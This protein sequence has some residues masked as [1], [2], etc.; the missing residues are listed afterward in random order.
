M[1]V[2]WNRIYHHSPWVIFLCS[3]VALPF[4]TI[5]GYL[6]PNFWWS[7]PILAKCFMVNSQFFM[8]NVRLGL[9]LIMLFNF[10]PSISQSFWIF[11]V[12]HIEAI[13]SV[14]LPKDFPPVAA[15]TFKK[16]RLGDLEATQ[17][18]DAGGH[19]GAWQSFLMGKWRENMDET[20]DEIGDEWIWRD[21]SRY[22]WIFLGDITGYPRFLMDAVPGTIKNV[23]SHGKLP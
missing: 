18:A 21:I 7:N 4:I 20:W 12:F 9:N 5:S 11:S 22:I 8:I 16:I 23:H 3:L 1:F 17:P 14:W 6:T 10:E 13:T 2:G 19:A 15:R